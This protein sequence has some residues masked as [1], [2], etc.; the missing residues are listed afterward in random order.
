MKTYM[1][2]TSANKDFFIRPALQQHHTSQYSSCNT[3][4]P[5]PQPSF[6]FSRPKPS[7]SL[8]LWVTAFGGWVGGGCDVAA[9]LHVQQ[10]TQRW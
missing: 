10:S 5:T 6:P 9:R 8:Q 7:P 3:P 2:R 4:T 1:K